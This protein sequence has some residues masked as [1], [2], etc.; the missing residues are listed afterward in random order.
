MKLDRRGRL[1]LIGTAAAAGN[2]SG[3]LGQTEPERTKRPNHRSFYYYYLG[4]VKW[5]MY[6]MM[7]VQNGGDGAAAVLRY[8]TLSIFFFS[9]IKNM[10]ICDETR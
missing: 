8:G 10:S 2:G 6:L 4:L 3:T 1:E 9:V 5:V 7:S